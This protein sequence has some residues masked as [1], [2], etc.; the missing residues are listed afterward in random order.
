MK[1]SE[2]T[3]EALSFATEVLVLLRGS[4]CKRVMGTISLD[5][6]VRTPFNG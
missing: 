4:A 3:D 1:D 6:D 5:M 2:S